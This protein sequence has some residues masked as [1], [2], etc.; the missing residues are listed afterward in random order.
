[1]KLG[2]VGAG[3]IGSR[4]ARTLVGAATV[5]ELLV[6]DDDPT[7]AGELAAALGSGVRAVSLDELFAAVAAVVIATPTPSHDALLRRATAAGLPAFCEKPLADSLP[8]TR[9]LVAVLAERGVPV[10]VGFQ[11]RFD[12]GYLA[13]RQALNSGQLGELRRIHAISCDPSPPPR[14]FL[15]SSGGLFRDL[16]IHDFD[17]VRWLSGQEVEQV[18]AVGV[19]RGP[20]WFG[21]IDD[22]DEAVALLTL[23]DGTLVTV[24]GSRFNGAGY[25]VR[26]ELAGTAGTLAVGLADATPVQSAEAATTFPRGPA[27]EQFW[28]R[29]QPAYQAELVAFT[30]LAAGRLPSSC[31][32]EDAL[33]ALY[34]AAAAD[35]SR[36]EN[37]PVR[38]AEV[39]ET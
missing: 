21:E 28:D 35:L 7:R 37:R 9:E 27:W 34:V 18:Y 1:M 12:P 20:S 26:M 24:Q 16:S 4:H 14:E 17:A 2:L 39:R 38:V 33:E 31:T 19:N 23:A 10:Q 25:D 8:R 6:A 5:T 3:R 22:V 29:F 11:R 32:P 36:R 15:A 13:A 30:E